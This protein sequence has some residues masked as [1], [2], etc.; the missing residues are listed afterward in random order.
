MKL[1]GKGSHRQIGVLTREGE[2]IREGELVRE[3]VT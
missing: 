2:I 1:L 3:R